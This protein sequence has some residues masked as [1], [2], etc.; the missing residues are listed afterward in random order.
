MLAHGQARVTPVVNKEMLNGV[1]GRAWR[2]LAVDML[3]FNGCSRSGVA[4]AVCWH[5]NVQWVFSGVRGVC[6][7]VDMEILTKCSRLSVAYAEPLK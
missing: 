6:R 5:R 2:M 7:A 4:F 1:H 3:M